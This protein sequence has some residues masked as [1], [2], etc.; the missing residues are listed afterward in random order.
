MR[1]SDEIAILYR[2]TGFDTHQ[3]ADARLISKFTSMNAA[4]VAF[5]AELKALN[6]WESTVLVQFSEFGR[7]LDSNT[8]FGA[9]RWLL[10]AI[11]YM[12]PSACYHPATVRFSQ[13]FYY[14]SII[15][16]DH[17]WGKLSSLVVILVFL[18][19]FSLVVSHL[20]SPLTIIVQ[21]FFHL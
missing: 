8:N 20:C 10:R 16:Q 6:L 19:S 15:W 12:F 11:I 14:T 21:H 18:F 5:V 7:T 1:S 13:C 9:V 17:A 2:H 4:F 3:N